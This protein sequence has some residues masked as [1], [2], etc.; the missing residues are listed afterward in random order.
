MILQALTRY[1]DILSEGEVAPLGYSTVGISFALNLSAQG[2]LLDIFPQFVPV[3]RGKKMLEVPRPMIVPEQVKRAGI[4]PTPNFLW[5][6]NAFVLGISEKDV[7]DPEY[8]LKRYEAF[9]QMHRELLAKA[10]CDAARAVITFLDRHDPL[11]A[12]EHPVITR[13]LEALLK[14]GNL[15][16]MFHGEF[17]HQDATIRR[18][19]EAHKAGKDAVLGQC[20]VTGEIAP[21]ARLHPSL[22]GVAG[23][24]SIGA[25]LVSFNERA[26]E[27]HNRLK[28]Q[29]LNSPVSE[30][31]TFAYTTALNYLLA[32]DN[33]NKK[34]II[35]D[36]TVVY[37]AESE[38]KE[39]EYAS[40]FANIF[41][42]EYVEEEPSVERQSR[43]RVEEG[44]KKVAEKVKRVQALDLSAL[45][46]DLQ[47]ENPRFY[48][49][50][51]APNAARV[52]VRFFITDP[53]QKIVER[54]MGHYRDLEI[55]KEFNNQP[56]YITIRH[57]LSE[58]I[59]KKARD[60]KA[61]P[62]MAGSVF[63]AILTDAPYPASLFYAII[64]RIRAD[65]DDSDKRIQKVNY[66]RAAVI[67]AFLLRK[68]RYQS[69]NPFQE[70]LVMSLNEQST[71]PAYVLGRLFAVLERAQKD[72]NPNLNRT[73]KDRYFT[74]ACASPASVFP[75]LLRLSQHHI[76]KAEY[77]YVNDR[78]IQDLLNLLDVNKNPI[79]T[80]LTLDEQGVFVLG[81][82]HQRAAF[83][84]KV[85][86]QSAEPT[87]FESQQS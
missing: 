33:P 26:Y 62:L 53:F 5:D 63:R 37:W 71:I 27:S 74:S 78:R 36:T 48:V 4:T 60:A 29:G 69:I 14:G 58:T 43:E 65:M 24:N 39:K 70:V 34:F 42:P 51:L 72:A 3:Q 47:E 50:G 87:L 9:R 54:I 84:A 45:L 85:D 52:S 10:D 35:G 6:N 16:F 22:K 18:L 68:Y 80:R 77:G 76:S 64:N 30:K 25:S 31:A 2:E 66:V 40:A 56:T 19:W 57:I 44:L 82:Y 41:E 23:A 46:A 67:K 21:I 11:R 32:P 17:V 1:Y 13:D 8:S 86:K 20:L 49:L 12:R 59:S 7:D 55:V 28:G 75:V 61:S 38:G 15:V 73:I 81:Y 79:P 83:Y